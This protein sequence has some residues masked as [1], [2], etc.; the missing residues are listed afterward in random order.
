MDW[1]TLGW[2]AC[3]A[4]LA[5]IAVALSLIGCDGAAWKQGFGGRISQKHVDFVVVDAQSTENVLV[6][7]LDEKTHRLPR[8][9]RTR[10]VP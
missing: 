2:L 6:V 5:I 8:P 4:A 3:L 10:R 9:K 7:E 1:K